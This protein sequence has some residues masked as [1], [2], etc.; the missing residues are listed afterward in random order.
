MGGLDD[1]PPKIIMINNAKLKEMLSQK[2]TATTTAPVQCPPTA[3]PERVAEQMVLPSLTVVLT[4]SLPFDEAPSQMK[5]IAQLLQSLGMQ[6][7]VQQPA[8]PATATVTPTSKPAP[9][10]PT[11][12]ARFQA[13][14][15]PAETT[16]RMTDKQKRMIFALVARKKLSPESFNEIL[17]SEFGHCD[18]ARLTKQEASSLIDKLM[19]GK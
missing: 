13:P 8:A 7:A 12:P 19:S 3:A 2:V 17:E 14:V 1:R 10:R 9:L 4:F 5:R 6:P 18:G 11:K 15:K 16:A